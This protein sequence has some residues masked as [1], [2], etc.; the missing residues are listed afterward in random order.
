MATAKP[1]FL[2]SHDATVL[3]SMALLI[4]TN[5]L[6]LD[7]YRLN[8]DTAYGRQIRDLLLQPKETWP[9]FHHPADAVA[10]AKRYLAWANRRLN[11]AKRSRRPTR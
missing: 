8:F 7:L 4:A 2:S 6:S 10:A 3:S 11:Q 9:A 5:E 1:R